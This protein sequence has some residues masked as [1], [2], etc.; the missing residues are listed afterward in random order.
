MREEQLVAE[1]RE[2]EVG[3]NQARED[4]EAAGARNVPSRRR[5]YQ[6]MFQRWSL[7]GKFHCNV[8]THFDVAMFDKKCKAS[9]YYAVLQP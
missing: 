1:V 6:K 5:D 2:V 9:L 7:T 4:Q 3:R 8:Y